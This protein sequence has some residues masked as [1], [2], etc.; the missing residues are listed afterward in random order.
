MPKTPQAAE[1]RKK[2]IDFL[3]KN[4]NRWVTIAQISKG[5]GKKHISNAIHAIAGSSENIYCDEVYIGVRHKRLF[6]GCFDS[7]ELAQKTV[8]PVDNIEKRSILDVIG[9]R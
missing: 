3:E 1:N 7:L 2:I 4:R 5:V 9:N 8:P 6:Y